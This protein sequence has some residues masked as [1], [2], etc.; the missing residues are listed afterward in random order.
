MGCCPKFYYPNNNKILYDSKNNI[1]YSFTYSKKIIERYT[2]IFI[3]IN[4]HKL[5][6]ITVEELFDEIT[7]LMAQNY[8]IIDEYSFKRL[9]L[10]SIIKN[11][12][13]TLLNSTLLNKSFFYL[14]YNANK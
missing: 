3:E 1:L 13:E 11:K 4:N 10:I 9:I 5:N 14:N 6:L 2:D 12:S 7:H 8:S